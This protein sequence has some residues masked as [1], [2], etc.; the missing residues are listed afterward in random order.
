MGG[1]SAQINAHYK[2]S[3]LDGIKSAL[4]GTNRVMHLK[5]CRNN[6]LTQMIRG[7]VSVD[8]FHGRD[9]SGPVVQRST[10]E[11]SQFFWLDMPDA[12]LNPRT[13]RPA[14]SRA[15]A[16]RKRAPMSSA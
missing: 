10:A 14:S 3:P 11:E 7:E 16:P 8:F 5:A 2:V 13:S 9:W 4:S 12:S 15:S 1:G 6:R